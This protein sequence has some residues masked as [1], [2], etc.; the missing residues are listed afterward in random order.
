QVGLSVPSVS[1]RLKKLEENKIIEGYFTKVNKQAFGLD[2][3]AFILVIMDSSKHYR[4]LIKHVDKHQSILEC[5][6]VLGEGSHLLKVLVK[7][8]EALEKLLSEIQ[9]WN[10]VTG[11]KTT[12]VLST[13]KETTA[14]NI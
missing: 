3:M 14:I 13:V 1:D 5:H 6:S 10:G 8:T 7:N 2:I 9:T 11:T 4:D 12:Y